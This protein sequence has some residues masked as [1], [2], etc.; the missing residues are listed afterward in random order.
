MLH[1]LGVILRVGLNMPLKLSFHTTTNKIFNTTTDVG[2]NMNPNVGFNATENVEL[3]KTTNVG[4]NVTTNVSP[5]RSN[6]MVSD[7]NQQTTEIIEKVCVF[8]KDA[9]QTPIRREP[10]LG[11]SYKT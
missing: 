4:R 8:L 2:V 5:L 9:Q 3:N 6:F 1:N 10:L 7:P 11:N